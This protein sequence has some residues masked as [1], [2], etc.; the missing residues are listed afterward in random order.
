M[1]AALAVR[2]FLVAIDAVAAAR[3]GGRGVV[4]AFYMVV[5]CTCWRRLGV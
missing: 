5:F 4:F 1:S 2:V 3:D